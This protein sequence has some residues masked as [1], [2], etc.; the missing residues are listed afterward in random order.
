MKKVLV[1]GGGGYIGSHVVKALLEAGDEVVT[2]DNLSEGHREAVVGGDLVQGDLSDG[3]LLQSLF[4]KYEFDAVMHFA[5]N[6]R[7]G[8][9]VEDPEKYYKNN[10]SNLLNLLAVMRRHRVKRIIFSSTA[11]VYGDPAA[12]PIAES[13]PLK[14]I[15]PYGFT[16]F[17]VENILGDYSR[18]YGLRSVSLRYFNA[19]GAD[20]SGRLGESHDPET[21]LIP[22]VL[23]VASGRLAEVEVFGTDYPTEDGTCI[24]DYIHVNDLALAH[25]AA[26]EHL[27][28]GGENLIVNLGNSR[29]Y[30]VKEIIRAAEG[31]TQRKIRVVHSPRRA[32]DPP[33]LVCDNSQ[34]RRQLHWQPKISSLEEIIQT[35][36]NWEQNRRY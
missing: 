17:V 20:P 14:P 2:F 27:R 23:A 9:S 10:V 35:A 3:P 21:H 18:A 31:I 22:R 6:C 4:S 34:A 30:S 33:V 15:N 25:L 5:A 29:G 7:V 28:G 1:T 24:R 32:G 26:L 12:T 8:E 36:W 16:K 19:A 11:A 13:H